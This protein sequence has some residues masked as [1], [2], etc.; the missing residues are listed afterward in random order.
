VSDRARTG[1]ERKADTLAKLEAVGADAWVATAPP[2]GAAYLVPLSYAWDGEHIVLAA[3]ATSPTIRNVRASGRARLGLGP[4][5]DVVVVDA[6]LD[7]IVDVSEAPEELAIAYARQSG[8]DPRRE[9]EP[10]AYALLHLRQV[11]AWREANELAGRRLMRD[12]E[13]L[14]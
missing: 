7:V 4:T 6:E 8:W 12:G 9:P 14:V 2:T 11:Q 10:Y 1:P 5:R 13:W 3:I